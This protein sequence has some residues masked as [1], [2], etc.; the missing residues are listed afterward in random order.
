[1]IKQL[2]RNINIINTLLVVTIIYFFTYYFSPTLNMQIKF[3]PPEPDDIIEVD[4]YTIEELSL[5]S[6]VDY[7]IISEENL[8]HPE[9]KI[10]VEKK[11]EQPLPKPEF[12]L[13]GT[14]VSENISIA[15]LED[16]KA[17]RN[18][19]GR[20]KRIIPLRKGQTLSGFKLEEIETDRI[21]M[22][23]GEEK[24]IVPINDPSR[25]K[26][27]QT[28]TTTQTPPPPPQPQPAPQPR[29]IQPKHNQ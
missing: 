25:P 17:P 6:N 8:F 5:P 20:G 19:P 11:V 29:R 16:L 14:L 23:R 15:Y 2:L 7:M 12:V 18:T 13:Y 10:P 1:M 24:I 22:T 9:R 27:R 3:T 28:V 21:V 26:E 4:E